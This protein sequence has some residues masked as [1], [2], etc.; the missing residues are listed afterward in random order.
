MVTEMCGMCA[1]QLVKG[2]CVEEY[3]GSLHTFCCIMLHT[4]IYVNGNRQYVC[5]LYINM[6][7]YC[8]EIHNVIIVLCALI[9]IQIPVDLFVRVNNDP[10]FFF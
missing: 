6:S 9:H 8:K 5:S 10:V 4:F 7:K 2:S 3:I 1:T